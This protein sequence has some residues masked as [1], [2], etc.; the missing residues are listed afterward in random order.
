MPILKWSN[1]NLSAG[2]GGGN[3]GISCSRKEHYYKSEEEYQEDNGIDPQTFYRPVVKLLRTVDTIDK[4]QARKDSGQHKDGDAEEQIA[5]IED[6]F[7][8]V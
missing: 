6:G 8:S 7:Q 3:Y 1:L 2:R 5:P 4:I